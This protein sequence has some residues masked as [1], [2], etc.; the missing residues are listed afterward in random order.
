MAKNIFVWFL[1]MIYMLHQTYL[2]K[3]DFFVCLYVCLCVFDFESVCSG[4]NL[5]KAWQS[6]HY[7]TR[8]RGNLHLMTS[9][10]GSFSHNIHFIR[11]FSLP[12]SLFFPHRWCSSKSLSALTN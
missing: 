2:C 7:T 1:F 12:A 9:N 5:L 11:L 10:F 4:H 3:D 8:F 6:V